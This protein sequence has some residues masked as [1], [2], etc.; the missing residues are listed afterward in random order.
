MYTTS[1]AKLTSGSYLIN[2]PVMSTILAY[3][4]SAKFDRILQNSSLVH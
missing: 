2:L 1:K 4:D 3:N